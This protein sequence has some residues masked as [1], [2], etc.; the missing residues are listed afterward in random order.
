MIK[1]ELKGGA[2]GSPFKCH[3][4]RTQTSGGLSAPQKTAAERKKAQA[5]REKTAMTE[6]EKTEAELEKARTELDAEQVKVEADISAEVTAA[7]RKEM[8]EWLGRNRL[9]RHAKAITA[10]AGLSGRFPV[11]SLKDLPPLV[12]RKR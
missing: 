4:T 11:M 8:V 1:G 5:Q 2:T 3:I 9:H 12:E 7:T 6:R 10:V